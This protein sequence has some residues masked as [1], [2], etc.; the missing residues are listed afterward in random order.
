MVSI[1]MGHWQTVQTKLRSTEMP[2]EIHFLLPNKY[3]ERTVPFGIFS[4]IVKS[5]GFAWPSKHVL[6]HLYTTVAFGMLLTPWRNQLTFAHILPTHPP[7]CSP[8]Y[9][10]LHFTLTFKA[11][12]SFELENFTGN[13]VTRAERNWPGH[14]SNYLH[15]QYEQGWFRSA[16]A[17]AQADLNHSLHACAIMRVFRKV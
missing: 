15:L 5:H 16:C 3:F 4:S 11:T 10:T 17:S 13:V 7:T 2:H 6:E 12:Y 8:S 9:N 1:W 14:Q